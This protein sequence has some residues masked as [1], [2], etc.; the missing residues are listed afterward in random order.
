[1]ASAESVKMGGLVAPTEP[2]EAQDADNAESG[3]VSKYQGQERTQ[4]AKEEKKEGKKDPE[5]KGWIE[6]CL[7]DMSGNPV[8][9]EEV[10][11]VD[12]DD[13]AHYTS[14]NDK[15]VARVDGI[16]EG[17]CKVTFPRLDAEAWEP[18]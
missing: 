15:G 16:T 18:A 1:M 13:E 2:D 5:K 6:V 10:E 12:P 3:E 9:G 8:C 11:V 4:E 17:S 14:T 7:V